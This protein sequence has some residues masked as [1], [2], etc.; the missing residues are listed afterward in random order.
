MSDELKNTA[1]EELLDEET[2]KDEGDIGF[3]SLPVTSYWQDVVR[4]F[5]KNRIAVVGLVMFLVIVFMCCAAPLFTNY[6]P[7]SDIEYYNVKQPPGGAHLLGTDHIG[8]DVWARLLY[9]GRTSVLTGVLVALFAAAIGVTIGL[10][11][12][13]YGGTVDA[14]L[15]RFTDIMLS[16]PFLILAIA[17][18]AALGSSQRNI[19]ISL[20]V[21]SWPG[22][23]RLTRSQVLAIKNSEYIEAAKVADFSNP[24]I[25]F[26]HV[27]PN[28]MGTIIIQLTLTIGGA[29]LS[30]AG[31][32]YLGMSPN[33][34][35]PEW[36]AMLN[37]GKPYLR[38][39]PYLTTIPGVAI[40]ITVLAI[41]WIGDGLRDA[42]DPKMRK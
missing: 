9:G 21:T 3:E 33:V 15:M 5:L 41:N 34:A 16:F 28:C 1:A 24:R 30:A 40:S 12:G 4:M 13:Y 35:K 29:I 22:F 6:D 38:T 42:F 26:K 27:L 7:V 39:H 14:L 11:A 31:L 20:A 37:D 17:I 8:R 2:V 18:M 10:V 19:I 23:A 36:G 25:L 32:A